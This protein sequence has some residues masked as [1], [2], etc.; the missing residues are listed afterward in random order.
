MSIRLSRI[1]AA[2]TIG[3]L[4]TAGLI[5]IVVIALIHCASSAWAA[6]SQWDRA[7]H[8]AVRLISAVDKLGPDRRVQVGLEFTLD[9]GWKIYWRSPGDAGLPPEPDWA[10][11]ANLASAT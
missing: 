9:P 3:G 7:D 4:R 11:S 2:L 5:T 1:E 10:G 8:A 6:A